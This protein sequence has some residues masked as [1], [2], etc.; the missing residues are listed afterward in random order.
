VV[1]L[2]RRIA[3]FWAIPVPESLCYAGQ[4][5]VNRTYLVRPLDAPTVDG[6]WEQELRELQRWLTDGGL[7]PSRETLKR[8]IEHVLLQLGDPRVLTSPDSLALAHAEIY[9]ARGDERL[10]IFLEGSSGD[11]PSGGTTIKIRITRQPEERPILEEIA[12]LALSGRELSQICQNLAVTLEWARQRWKAYHEEVR[13]LLSAH[14]GGLSVEQVILIAWRLICALRGGRSSE[15]L[16][17]QLP[18]ADDQAYAASSPWAVS[19]FNTCYSAGE[20][21][22]GWQETVRRLV[23]GAFTL[24]ETLVDQERYSRAVA[25]LDTTPVLTKIAGLSL[26]SLRSL[27][28]KIRPGSQPLYD[29]LV[30]LQRYAQAVLQINPTTAFQADLADL[31][32]RMAQLKPQLTS[33]LDHLAK[34]L[35]LLRQ[36]AG[37]VGVPWQAAWASVLESGSALNREDLQ[38][39]YVGLE[40]CYDQ[41][42]D[43]VAAGKSDIWV[44]QDFR[45]RLK[46]LV[47]HPYWSFAATL[48]VIQQEVIRCARQRYRHDAKVLT[49]TRSYHE[50]L[51]V[52]RA[53]HQELG[54]GKST[55]T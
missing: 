31:A 50:L 20:V 43:N 24:R 30:P 1:T 46:P 5:R 10:P 8:G 19:P 27:P 7:Y 32:R 52:I 2:D 33:D 14:L 13:A 18:S 38:G 54:H 3:D 25:A 23:I 28:Y 11:Q 39:L 15:Y 49:G 22:V 42:R 55:T 45:Q 40:N 17:T 16:R 6:H 47:L 12:Y 36:G 44:Y 35:D 51:E 48:H 4:V 9:Y 21:L 29:L 41:A 53:V 37:E 26:K 34:Q